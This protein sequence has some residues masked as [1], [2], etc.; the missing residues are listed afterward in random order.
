MTPVATA[1]KP[2]VPQATPLPSVAPGIPDATLERV[3]K[4]LRE[5]RARTG[6]SERQVVAILAARGVAVSLPMLRRAERTG[7]LDLA[8][9]ALVADVYGTT[10]DCLAGRRL[11]HR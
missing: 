3:A 7:V 2:Y 4:A 5:A 9:A 6:M 10:T 11:A 8:F 1:T